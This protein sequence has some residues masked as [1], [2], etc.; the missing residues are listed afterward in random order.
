MLFKDTPNFATPTPKLPDRSPYDG[1][2][3]PKELSQKQM[4]QLRLYENDA[5]NKWIQDV[6]K[7][8]E[9]LHKMNNKF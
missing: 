8:C 4:E 2:L 1:K 5:M 9:V 7:E 6:L 3:P